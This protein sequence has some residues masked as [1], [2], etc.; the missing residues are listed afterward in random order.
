MGAV[1]LDFVIFLHRVL[2]HSHYITSP[3]SFWLF[4]SEDSARYE[5]HAFPS[6]LTA[7][8]LHTAFFFL[9]PQ[10]S[11]DNALGLILDPHVDHPW[12]LAD[13]AHGCPLRVLSQRCPA[14]GASEAEFPVDRS[15]CMDIRTGQ[16]RK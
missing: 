9:H 12:P 5:V 10:S 8:V 15:A 11:L 4:L 6:L 16:L 2:L 14:S 7:I 1:P 13:M 3:S